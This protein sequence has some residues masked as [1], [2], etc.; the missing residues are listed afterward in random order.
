MVRWLLSPL[1]L[2]EA[3]C[4]SADMRRAVSMSATV[5]LNTLQGRTQTQ[6]LLS[7][8]GGSSFGCSAGSTGPCCWE[9]HDRI[10]ASRDD[11]PP[12]GSGPL[13]SRYYGTTHS[14]TTQAITG[15]HAAALLVDAAAACP[16]L[17]R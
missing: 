16:Q 15:P 14:C 2:V 1:L 8:D 10:T 3:F 4:C 17:T 13:T 9:H 12:T 5:E 7:Q 11:V 6:H